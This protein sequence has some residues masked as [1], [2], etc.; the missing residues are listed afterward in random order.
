M[1]NNH[2]I[3]VNFAEKSAKWYETSKECY[4]D[5]G[6]PRSNFSVQVNKPSV[7]R[8]K[9]MFFTGNYPKYIDFDTAFKILKK[10]HGKKIDF[11]KL[12]EKKTQ[13]RKFKRAK[14]YE[15]KSLRDHSEYISLK[16]ARLI[17]MEYP[18]PENCCQ[19]C[20]ISH[21]GEK[22]CDKVKCRAFERKDG[23]N[24]YYRFVELDEH[25]QFRNEKF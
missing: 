17:F 22:Y 11:D 8:G 20:F 24:G 3:F 14:K 1:K 5:V 23:K 15:E 9:Y 2:T 21:F 10:M 16:G 18:S 6:V 19:N 7:S 12:L 13:K 4:M 25:Q